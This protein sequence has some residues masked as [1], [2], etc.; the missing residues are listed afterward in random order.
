MSQTCPAK[1]V[2]TGG[3]TQVLH[4][5]VSI[6][7]RGSPAEHHVVRPG[8]RMDLIAK[9]MLIITEGIFCKTI[10]NYKNVPISVI[11]GVVQ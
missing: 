11:E 9:K 10:S 5:Q 3:K 2:G 8:K 4:T 6:A 1:R 7:T